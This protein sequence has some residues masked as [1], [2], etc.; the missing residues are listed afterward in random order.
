MFSKTKLFPGLFINYNFFLVF[1]FNL[2]TYSRLLF[3]PKDTV[4][5]LSLTLGSDPG[6]EVFD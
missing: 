4:F 2:G 5:A 3:I 1:Q 6:V